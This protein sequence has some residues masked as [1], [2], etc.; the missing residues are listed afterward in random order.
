MAIPFWGM[1]AGAALFAGACYVG[2]KIFG[3]LSKSERR[4]QQELMDNHAAYCCESNRRYDAIHSQYASDA[5]RMRKQALAEMREK[6]A[7]AIAEA[8]EK[9]DLT[10]KNS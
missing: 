8:K 6:I 3:A 2:A 4:R 7:I 1:A 5:Q 9:T 10:T